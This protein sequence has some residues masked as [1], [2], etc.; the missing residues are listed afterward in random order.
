MY[1]VQVYPRGIVFD[2]ASEPRLLATCLNKTSDLAGCLPVC[3]GVS[4][5]SFPVRLGIV[6]Y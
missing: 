5:V 3:G 2:L 4:V 1:Q 6:R